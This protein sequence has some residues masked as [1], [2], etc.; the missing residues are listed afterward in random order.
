MAPAGLAAIERAQ[1]NGSWVVLDSS[2]RL[3]VPDDLAAA[4]DSRP[5]AMA[6]FTA[7]PPS[8]R[9]MQLAWVALAQ[10]PETRATRIAQVT[11]AAAR[12]ERARS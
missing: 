11:D 5:G 1:A 4:L 6:N 8:A 12:N 7:F 3:E 10:R 2:E 9:K